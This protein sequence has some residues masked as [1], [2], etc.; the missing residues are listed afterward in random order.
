MN[1]KI[2]FDL[3]NNNSNKN[4]VNKN[5]I[6]SSNN[7]YLAEK[8]NTLLLEE[9]IL[10]TNNLDKSFKIINDSIIDISKIS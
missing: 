3:L 9:S 4:I 10:I 8:D 7:K 2:C 5:E 1:H 6:S